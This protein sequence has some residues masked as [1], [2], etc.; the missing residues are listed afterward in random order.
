MNTTIITTR[1]SANS[2]RQDGDRHRA[3]RAQ[4]CHREVQ[5]RDEVDRLLQQLR[6]VPR[7]AAPDQEQAGQH[8]A[9]AVQRGEGQEEHRQQQ[10][11][12]VYVELD[13]VE[14]R[15]YEEHHGRADA[16]HQQSAHGHAEQDG[17]H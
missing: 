12:L 5:A 2:Q 15:A 17:H 14:H 4:A 8:H 7:L 9:Q 16:A 3:Q 11:P 1:T 10:Q 6:H 13:V